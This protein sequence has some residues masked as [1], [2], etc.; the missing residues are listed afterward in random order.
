[1]KI[2]LIDNYDSFT[3]NLV[4][5]LEQVTEDEITVVRNDLITLEEV[6]NF[7]HIMFSPGPGLPKDAGMMMEIIRVWHKTKNIFGIC[8]GHQ[9]IGEFFGAKL[10]NLDEVHHGV[11]TPIEIIHADPIFQDIPKTISVGRYHSWV[12]DEKNIPNDLMVTAKDLAGEIM[13]IQHRTLPIFGVQFHP[14]SIMTTHGLQMIRNW[15][16]HALIRT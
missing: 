16:S 11:A 1:M 7:D 4:H 8:L 14:E 9:A 13:A 5:Y 10:R 15:Y 2:L 3:Y 6:G 12:L